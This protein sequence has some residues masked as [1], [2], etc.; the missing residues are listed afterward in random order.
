MMVML[1]RNP[2][3]T[4]PSRSRKGTISIDGIIEE[5]EIDPDGMETS[6][7]DIF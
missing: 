6:R 3:N 4:V 1:K 7:R 2:E 5:H